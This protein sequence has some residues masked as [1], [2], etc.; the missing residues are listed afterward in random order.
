MGCIVNGPGEMV[1]ADYGY[2]GAAEG[3]VH[4]YKGTVPVLKNVPEKDA[5]QK[6]LKVIEKDLTVT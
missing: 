6:L 5:V 3:K 4:I 1:G 2:V